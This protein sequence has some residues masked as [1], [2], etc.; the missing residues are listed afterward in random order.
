MVYLEN[1]YE[2]C[3]DLSQYGKEMLMKDIICEIGLNPYESNVVDLFEELFFKYQDIS[4]LILE[5][6]I[7]MLINLL[8]LN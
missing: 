7:D 4:R 6:F 1:T 2:L 5:I 3:H 8:I